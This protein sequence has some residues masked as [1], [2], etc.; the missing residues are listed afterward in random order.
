MVDA[1]GQFFNTGDIIVLLGK[2]PEKIQI[3]DVIVFQS[4]LPHK[5]DPIIHRVIEKWNENDLTYFTTKG[6]H[7]PTIHGFESKIHEDRIIGKAYLKVP[8]LGYVKLWFVE[9]LNILGLIT[10]SITQRQFFS[11]FPSY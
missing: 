9:L 6:D 1:L 2:D 8:F 3:G 4:D 11:Y 10:L 5:R 7:N